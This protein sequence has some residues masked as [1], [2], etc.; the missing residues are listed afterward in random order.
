MRRI[1]T[2]HQSDA[3]V[4]EA[5]KEA[6]RKLEEAYSDIAKLHAP[7]VDEASE[8]PDSQMSNEEL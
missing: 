1:T 5:T 2:P 8:S 6:M 7:N 4:L 3:V